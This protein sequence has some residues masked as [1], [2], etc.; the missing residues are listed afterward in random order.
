MENF[1]KMLIILI[2][3]MESVHLS[4]GKALNMIVQKLWN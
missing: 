2:K 4:G 3:L 1:I